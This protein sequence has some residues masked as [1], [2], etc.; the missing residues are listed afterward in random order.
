MKTSIHVVVCFCF[1]VAVIVTAILAG[2]LASGRLPSPIQA[3]NRNVVAAQPNTEISMTATKVTNEFLPEQDKVLPV[4]E[5]HSGVENVKQPSPSPTQT[6]TINGYEVQDPMA[7]VALQFVGSDPNA[8][9]YWVSAINDS[10]VPPEER[11]DLIEDLNE[12]GLS[13]PHHPS[14]NDMPLI[15]SR[16][17]LI[18]QLAPTAMDDVDR[19]AFSEAYKDLKD[20]LNGQDPQ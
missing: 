10:T 6:L 3:G 13:D 1:V 20:L 5:S 17:Q 14:A 15:M 7:R 12:D 19:K 9:A 4:P 11:K 2:V 8:D 16:M 18:E